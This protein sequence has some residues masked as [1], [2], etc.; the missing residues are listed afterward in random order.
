MTRLDSWRRAVL[1]TTSAPATIGVVMTTFLALLSTA[2]DFALTLN[3]KAAI[4]AVGFIVLL[5][6]TRRTRCRIAP[7]G[8]APDQPRRQGPPTS[9]LVPQEGPLLPLAGRNRVSRPL[10]SRF[11]GLEAPSP[12]THP[13]APLPAQGWVALESPDAGVR[14]GQS[15][16]GVTVSPAR[17]AS[18]ARTAAETLGL[19]YRWPGRIDDGNWC[20]A[21]AGQ[22]DRYRG[23]DWVS[24]EG[25]V[26]ERYAIDTRAIHA[27]RER[28]WNP[29]FST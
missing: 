1:V 29:T 7:E 10:V 14:S 19:S 17:L 20:R 28:N 21:A 2:A 8:K 16:D 25:L 18:L 6:F 9:V 22:A 5:M 4:V 11:R 15:A 26:S 27:G 13:I 12:C 24:Q 3:L 23:Y